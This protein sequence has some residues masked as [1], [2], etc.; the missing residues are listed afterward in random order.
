MAKCSH[1]LIRILSLSL[2]RQLIILIICTKNLARYQYEHG[3][4][5]IPVWL[6]QFIYCSLNKSS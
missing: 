5:Q 2:I 1:T 3:S 4:E 6:Y